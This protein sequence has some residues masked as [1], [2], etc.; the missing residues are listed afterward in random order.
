MVFCSC[1]VLR[2]GAEIC[3]LCVVYIQKYGATLL[4]MLLTYGSLRPLPTSLKEAQKAGRQ[5][6]EQKFLFQIG[7]VNP[8]GINEPLFILL[9]FTLPGTN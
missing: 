2:G 6:L 1:C 4:V 5:T 3:G 9:F 7:T 8:H